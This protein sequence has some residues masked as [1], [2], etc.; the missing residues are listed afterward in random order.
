MALIL[1][2]PSATADNVGAS[3]FKLMQLSKIVN[4]TI[5]NIIVL[6]FCNTNFQFSCFL[7]GLFILS[8]GWEANG[9]KV[10]KIN[11]HKDIAN[12]LEMVKFNEGFNPTND[13]NLTVF[14]RKTFTPL[15][16]FSTNAE[17][18]ERCIDTVIK[19][20]FGQT[21]ITGL[22]CRNVINFLI[23]ELTNN[24]ADHS[25][26]ECGIVFTQTYPS[27]GFFRYYNCR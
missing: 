15:F 1:P 8:K 7:S 19:I 17:V 9:K 2:V 5:D 13:E 27:K 14:R 21:K 11:V 26:S 4:S 10:S 24:V 12:Y 16:V 23:T 6:D 20:V 25:E 3:V 18:R 22:D